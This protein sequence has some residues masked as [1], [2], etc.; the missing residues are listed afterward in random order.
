MERSTALVVVFRRVGRILAGPPAGKQL[1]VAVGEGG[2]KGHVGRPEEH[3]W[4]KILR[5]EE[6]SGAS[7]A[8]CPLRLRGRQARG[9]LS[10]LCWE[11]RCVA[12]GESAAPSNCSIGGIR[13]CGPGGSENPLL[14]VRNFL[15]IVVCGL[16]R[17]GLRGLL[18]ETLKGLL[19]L[20]NF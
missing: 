10:L 19:L 4:R 8:T 3:W 5:I 7:P 6:G 2:T 13:R 1:P 20:L 9:G 16:G 15:L 18:T 14:S 11:E 17:H 12:W